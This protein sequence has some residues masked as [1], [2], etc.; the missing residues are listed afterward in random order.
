[1]GYVLRSVPVKMDSR[2]KILR[3]LIQ[4]KYLSGG[5]LA[6]ICGITRVAV[7]KHIN[8]LIS[9]RIKIKIHPNQGY[10]LLDLSN[11]VLPEV[12]RIELK[13]DILARKIIW[14]DQI[15]ST[16][17]ALKRM[18]KDDLE[19]GTLVIAEQQTQGK[20]RK[21][22][23]WYSAKGKDLLFS[24]LFYPRLPYPYLPLFNI[25]GALAVSRA[26]RNYLN[27][28]AFVKWP[29]DVL[30]NEKKVAGVLTEFVAEI[31]RL[32][33]LILGIGINVNSSPK[34]RSAISLSKV[35]DTE[36]CRVTLLREILMELELFYR[37]ISQ[38]KTK[39]IGRIWKT[40][41]YHYNKIIT[42]SC[43]RKKLKGR[44]LG[45]DEYGNLLLKMGKRIKT[46]YPTATIKLILN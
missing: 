16:N 15:D 7:W 37:K 18:L 39:E 44:S 22:A 17:E 21:G 6:R 28:S 2:E 5:E 14:Y 25:I 34:L 20:G 46:L 4:K 26:I 10:E 31:D 41:S 13:T 23:K 19:E 29:N 12:I 11:T 9:H 3:L 30:L 42:V 40:L 45:L 36:I 27:L 24:I 1:M 35:K 43:E 8:Y 32:D 38:K 33:K